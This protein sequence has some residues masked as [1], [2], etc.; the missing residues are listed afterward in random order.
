MGCC[1]WGRTESD[2]TEMTERFR[3]GRDLEVEVHSKGKGFFFFFGRALKESRFYLILL[4]LFLNR[5][6]RYL[7]TLGIHIY[8]S[9]WH[10][11]QGTQELVQV[12]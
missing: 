4:H 2:T 3:G 10:G 11:P 7:H 1:L 8:L 6:P 9:F 5:K 12:R